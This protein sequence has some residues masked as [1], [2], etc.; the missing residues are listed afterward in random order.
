MSH[1]HDGFAGKLAS[2][3]IRS[4]LT[5][6]LVIAS[7]LLGLLAVI[8]LPREE[9][10]QIEVP[11]IDV[12]VAM[13]GSSAKEVEE[14]VIRPMEQL[15]WEID[16]VEYVYS[17]AM[18]GAAMSIV[19]FEVG[20]NET[21]ALVDVHSKLQANYDRIPFGVTPPLV[22]LKTI[23]D[24]PILALTLHADGDPA[25]GQQ[26]GHYELRR[27]AAEM[28][29]AIKQVPKVA[30]TSIIGGPQRQIRVQ[31]DPVRLAAH[32]LS[33]AALVPVLRAANAQ[34]KAGDLVTDNRV[35][36]IESGG[37]F[38][39]A[40]DVA[41]AVVGVF[42]GKP[43]YLRDVATIVDGPAEVDT[44]VFFGDHERSG[45]PAV[46]LAVAKRPGT[47]A[48]SVAEEV[49]A[50]V[51]T[52]RGHLIPDSCSITI[53]RHYGETAAEKSNELLVHMAM[54]VI[55]VSILIMFML[56]W[57]ES[58]VVLVA[59]P[60]TLS[61]TLLVFYLY[62]YTLNRITLFALIFSIGILVDDAIVVVENIVRHR[63]LPQNKGRSL[64]QVAVEA[65]VEVGNPTILA[66]WAVI[67]A[68]LPMASV[69]GLMGPYM[70][71]IPVGASA[72]MIFSLIIAFIVTPW[73]S[74]IVLRRHRGS[75]QDET[76]DDGDATEREGTLTR[77]Y[78][79]VMGPL[80]HTALWRWSFLVG[81]VVLLLGAV[82]LVPTHLVQVK[83]LPFDNKSEFQV[84]VD[85]PEG[86]TLEETAQATRAMAATL[87]DEPELLDYQVYV[88]TASPFNFNG[89]VRHYYL[90]SGPNVADIQVNLLPRHARATQS[91]D[92][93][94]RVRGD[95]Q[96][97][98][99]RFGANVT[100]AEV[101][102]G[103]PVL[104]TLV[105]EIYAPSE[106][107]R[108]ALARDVKAIFAAT[109]GVVDIDWYVEAPQEQRRFVIDKDKAMLHGIPAATIAE[110]LAI[111]VG[112]R[113]V[114]L[115]HAPA[116]NEDVEIVLELPERR[117][118]S[119]D[120]ILALRLH[121]SSGPG[122]LGAHLVPLSELVRVESQVRERTIH[123]KNMLP[124][125][126]VTGDVAGSIESPVYAILQM[127]ERLAELD[128]RDYGGRDGD[129]AIY[130][131]SLPTH[132]MEPAIKWDGEWHITIEVFRDLGLAFVA[133]CVLIYLLMVGW[134][135][136]FMT[137]LVVMAAIPFSLIGILP[138][139]A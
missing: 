98:A 69:G 93:A 87:R 15:L 1:D 36:S 127:N 77:L 84:I 61:L 85:M 119:I 135:K 44:Y 43:V 75:H 8:Q 18:P 20:E 56:G 88:G 35:L 2:T 30:E 33:P 83:M 34:F 91:H 96:A 41:G 51:A 39:D 125:T 114:G 118:G 139:H 50:K 32:Q 48:I 26:L 11:M 115:L 102:P 136:S 55:S 132:T 24:V 19:R 42:Q 9:E 105:A 131:A 16:G 4:K 47:N 134:F 66:T 128:G 68:I 101:P 62:G 99:E 28:Q 65:T 126:Y 5:P 72:A 80:I 112:G 31:L 92:I 108:L 59:I 137:P 109:D 95:L 14:R 21:R 73:A 10:P 49:L 38:I 90:R 37:F 89:L 111:A 97:V 22:K 29:D 27:I 40:D 94:K 81:I 63:R 86:S 122:G 45:D 13:P 82:A 103:P 12:L 124:V 53:T 71:P 130:N 25:A 70:R 23:N 78:R 107:Q 116:E 120:D 57:R 110:T 60:T 17:T 58:L 113:Q 117:R 106:E 100:V 46:T 79:Q 6:L 76:V 133:V 138:A 3:F 74:L 129:I 52:L 104:Q 123:H 54:A 64:A 7:I 121:S 67:A